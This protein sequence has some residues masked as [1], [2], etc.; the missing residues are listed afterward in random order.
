MFP[1]VVMHF[2]GMKLNVAERRLAI[3][4][5]PPVKPHSEIQEKYLS[6]YHKSHVLRMVLDRRAN[7]QFGMWGHGGYDML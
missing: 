3:P 2:H 7:C 1:A 4:T 5:T 6:K